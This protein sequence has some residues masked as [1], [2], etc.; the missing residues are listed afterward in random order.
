MTTQ[1][2]A[3]ALLMAIWRCGEP[4]AFLHHSDQGN[5]YT[6]THFGTLMEDIGGACK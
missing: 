6:S 1:P 3:D 4:D 5:Q 2:V